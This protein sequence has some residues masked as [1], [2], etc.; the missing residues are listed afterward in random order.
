MVKIMV[1]F[2]SKEIDVC[3]DYFEQPIIFIIVKVSYLKK[4]LNPL[5]YC[6]QGTLQMDSL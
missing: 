2:Q 4:A 6:M 3:I 5:W 1:Y